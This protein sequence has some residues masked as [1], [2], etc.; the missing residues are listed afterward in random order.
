M[1]HSDKPTAALGDRLRNAAHL[2]GRALGIVPR[3]AVLPRKKC[4]H[5]S[6]ALHG[7]PRRNIHDA[8]RLR[9]QQLGVY[10]HCG[11]AW[12]MV[13]DQA[14]VWY[15]DDEAV[16]TRAGAA[17]VPEPLWRAPLQQGLRLVRCQEG[18][19]LEGVGTHSGLRSR[20]FSAL[21]AEADQL[22]F[23]RD[24]GLPDTTV[25]T[26]ATVL[27]LAAQPDRRWHIS[28]RHARLWPATVWGVLALITI[29]GSIAVTQLV[30][31]EQLGRNLATLQQ[32]RAALA[33]VGRN[34]RAIENALA[35]VRP[36]ADAMQALAARPRQTAWLAALA[37]RGIVSPQGVTL[38]EWAFR[39]GRV[40]MTLRI[41]A[42]SSAGAVLT[43]VQESRLFTD[44]TLL[45][46][47]PQGVL[48]I[49]AALAGEEPVDSQPAAEQPPSSSKA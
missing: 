39:D 35:D 42:T 45:P 16:D 40:T 8:I 19:E 13:G 6:L 46:D 5:L 15:W 48:R 27:P 4:Q 28:T 14:H 10:A 31:I 32:E 21:P 20:W 24:L 9:L 23:I 11:F 47:P 18:F 30:Y 38:A 29:A 33:Q 25:L 41:P 7:V 17:P 36:T 12:R 1:P 26:G 22:S 43:T 34:T 2:C 49:Q 3:S 44:I 37:S